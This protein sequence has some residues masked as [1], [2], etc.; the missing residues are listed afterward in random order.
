MTKTTAPA[1]SVFDLNRFTPYRLA[2]AAEKMSEALAKLYRERFG[3]SIPEWRV[4]VHVADAGEASVRDIEARVMME[5]SM[6]SRAA[7]RLEARGLL[8]KAINPDDRRLLKLRLTQDGQVLMAELLPLAAEF[9]RNLETRLAEHISS[10]EAALDQ[11]LNEE[12]K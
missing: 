12:I 3:I 11:I 2:V 1:L 4:L 10:F 6:V 9:Q 7:A 8:S 5:K